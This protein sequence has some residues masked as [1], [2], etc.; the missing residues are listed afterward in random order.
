ML[1]VGLKI[2]MQVSAQCSNQC[3]Q[4]HVGLPCKAPWAHR[5]RWLPSRTKPAHTTSFELYRFILSFLFRST[6]HAD[7][8]LAKQYLEFGRD[9]RGLAENLDILSSVI[10]QAESSLQKERQGVKTRVRWDRRSLIEIVGDYDSTLQECRELLASN[11]RYRG[12]SGPFR[13]LEWN[14]LV[15]PTADQLRQ[16]IILHNS[17]VLHILKPFEM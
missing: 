6:S 9:V 1:T 13:N 2:T 15:Q 12:G 5:H 11:A 7:R 10:A 17:K 4:L 3:F 8:L 14:L 16:R